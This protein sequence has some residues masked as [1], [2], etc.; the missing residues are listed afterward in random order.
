MSASVNVAPVTKHFTSSILLWMRN[1]QPRQKGMDY[2]K[3]PHSKI[4]SASKGSDEYRQTHLAAENPGLWPAISGIETR[5]PVDRKVDGVAEV[6]FQSP[7][8]P[9]FGRPQTKLAYADEINVF[10]RTLLYLGAPGSSRWYGVAEMGERVGARAL[11][12]LR[13]RPGVSARAF[14]RLINAEIA[15]TLAATAALTELRTQ[16]FLPWS[17]ALWDTP[18]VAHDNPGDQRFHASIALGFVDV[19]ARGAFFS[20]DLIHGL[21]DTLAPLTS[22]IHAYE[23]AETL[24]Y[25]KDGAIL[26]DPLS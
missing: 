9:L 6:A 7:L 22:A 15:P 12:L 25:V 24:T 21:S 1:D 14:R 19:V 18:D 23:A 17:R 26:P 8:S 11:V 5:I 16:T 4:I 20:G 10:R 2:W 13:R 3:G